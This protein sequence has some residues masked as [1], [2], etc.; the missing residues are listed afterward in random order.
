MEQYCEL[1]FQAAL[2]GTASFLILL[3]TVKGN[4]QITQLITWYLRF[5]RKVCIQCIQ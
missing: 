4:H 5:L 2:L 3:G 1:C